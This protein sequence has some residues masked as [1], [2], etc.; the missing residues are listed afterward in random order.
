MCCAATQS[1]LESRP[2]GVPRFA[3]Y[4]RLVKTPELRSS[5]ASCNSKLARNCF[6][7]ATIEMLRFEMG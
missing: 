4:H 3:A 1:A 7:V 2:E 6:S 5:I